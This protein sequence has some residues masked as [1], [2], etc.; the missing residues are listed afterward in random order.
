MPHGIKIEEYVDTP[1]ASTLASEL[2]Q[3]LGG[4]YIENLKKSNRV[5]IY[6]E[7][8]TSPSAEDIYSQMTYITYLFSVMWYRKFN[9]FQIGDIWYFDKNKRTLRKIGFGYTASPPSGIKGKAV[10]FS[11]N[12]IDSSIEFL[13][14]FLAFNFPGKFDL[15]LGDTD[16]SKISILQ[17]AAELVELSKLTS[18]TY[19][20]IGYFAPL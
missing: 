10:F 12:E 19:H 15:N 3:M 8:I 20:K 4:Y 11:N 9:T 5:I 2:K 1:L 6:K 14:T 13:D 16:Y 7:Y 18:N 17:R